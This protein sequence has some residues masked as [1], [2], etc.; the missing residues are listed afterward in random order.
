VPYVKTGISRG[1]PPGPT[2]SV[3]YVKT[4]KSRGRPPGLI[5]P[6]TAAK[7]TY[8]EDEEEDEGD[9]DEYQDAP[10]PSPKKKKGRGRPPLAAGK[11]KSIPYVKTGISRGRPPG[12]SKSVPY[13]KT[14]K[15]RGRPP[16]LI[17]KK[18][19]EEDENVKSDLI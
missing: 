19:E 15:S 14:G 16:G 17:K 18:D 9:S 7:A 1:R 12:P 6:K 2:K 10:A 11:K 13:V 8:Y 3:P 5:T 4:G